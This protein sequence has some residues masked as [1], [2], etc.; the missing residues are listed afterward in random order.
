MNRDKEDFRRMMA[1]FPEVLRGAGVKLTP[2]RLEIYREIARSGNHPD[3]ES[4]YKSLRR[5]MP[6]LSLDTV[7]RTLGMFV[8]LGLITTIRPLNARIRYDANTGV[9]HHFV[10]TRCGL[11]RDFE[12]PHF[13]NLEVQE[14]ARAIGSVTSHHVEL[15]GLCAP[16]SARGRNGKKMSGNHAIT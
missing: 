12:E 6:S 4:I 3:I 15:R 14:A 13:D 8:E 11:A 2:Q 16:C 5:R 1:R 9:H 7:Y 10:C